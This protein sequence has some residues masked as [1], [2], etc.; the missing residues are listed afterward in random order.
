MLLDEDVVYDQYDQVAKLHY[1]ITPK[2]VKEYEPI[3]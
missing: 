1:R 2:H 3:V